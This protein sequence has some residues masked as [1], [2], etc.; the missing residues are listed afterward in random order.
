MIH[1]PFLNDRE[2]E[3][4]LVSVVLLA[5]MA[6]LD[7]VALLVPLAMTELRCVSFHMPG[8]SVI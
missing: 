8:I 2:T 7:L 6:H 1:V 3:V 4:S 5:L